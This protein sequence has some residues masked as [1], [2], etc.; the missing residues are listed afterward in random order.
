MSLSRKCNSSS[1]DSGRSRILSRTTITFNQPNASQYRSSDRVYLEPL[2]LDDPNH[3]K[4]Q[5]RRQE[6]ELGVHTHQG[7][8]L[9]CAQETYPN[10]DV[11]LEPKGFQ[12]KSR[13]CRGGLFSTTLKISLCVMILLPS[14]PQGQG[15]PITTKGDLL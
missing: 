9:Q 10:Q 12:K 4:D 8:D 14:I 7:L 13:S 11:F 1:G 2:L 6:E 3:F 5:E 15:A